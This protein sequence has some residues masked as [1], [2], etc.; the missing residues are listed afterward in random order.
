MVKKIYLITVFK[1]IKSKF[2][3]FLVNLLIVLLSI[4]LAAALGF[5]PYGLK[6][7][8]LEN[9]K[10]LT[11]D[12]TIKLKGDL[13][14][15]SD[16]DIDKIKEINNIESVESFFAMDS[17]IDGKFNRLY[18]VDFSKELLAPKLIEGEMP[19]EFGEVLIHK[20]VDNKAN[21]KIGDKLTLKLLGANQEVTVVGIVNTPLYCS[22][23]P[24]VA[25]NDNAD[26]DNP[27]HIDSIF[28]M[29][30]ENLNSMY[31]RFIPK[32]DLYIT[33][34]N[35]SQYMTP[36]YEKEVK[37][38][39]DEI[40]TATNDSYSY[41]TL[42]DNTSY[43]MFN[44]FNNTIHTISVI[45]PILFIIV[46]ALVIYLI[47][48]KLILDE[49]QIIAC[50]FSQGMPKSMIANKYLVF[51]LLSTLLG[52][53]GGYFVGVYVLPKIF[54][55][56]YELV[57][58]MHGVPNN[59][60]SPIG[61]IM[62]GLMILVSI[63]VT[64]ASVYVSLRETPASLMLQKAPKPGKKILLEKIGFIWNRLSFS[65]KS[66]IR[67]IFRN[68]KNLILTSLSVIGSSI[69]ILI[70]FSLN[71]AAISM[72]ESD[73]Y[74][75]VAPSMGLISLVIIIIGL[76]IG[77]LVIYAL[78]SMNIDDREREIAV[79]KVLGYYDTESALYASR[80]LVF[81]T[82]V[83]GLIGIP[84][85]TLVVYVV[86]TTIDFA[87]LSDVQWY[88]YVSTYAIT[89]LSSLISSFLLYPKIKRIDFNI[90]LKSVE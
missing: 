28:Y 6:D 11:P 13:T 57:Y 62:A 20:N 72:Y 16:S 49:R 82:L 76:A 54:Y 83:A 24:E 81:I 73:I 46:C 14:K 86:F 60:L 12:I 51:S 9:Y 90:S 2:V 69:L 80:E 44:E 1:T 7:S 47:T 53:I 77:I 27:D 18:V 21:Y 74:K 22:T 55:T 71:D 43:A 75:N 38:L 70:G 37:A 52:A 30:F 50:E 17:E 48:E 29:N 42:Y 66:S 79:L 89:S 63:I 15:I 45:F 32:T 8:Y 68:K 34:K 87:K 33:M 67:N 56:A 40:K 4:S 35:K 31:Q 88:S 59:V 26:T 78:A 58:D 64:L 3:R 36:E 10:D 65:F 85:G 84:I 39:V 19:K 23:R 25:W 5:L 61:V 41:L